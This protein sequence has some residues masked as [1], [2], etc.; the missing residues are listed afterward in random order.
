MGAGNAPLV[1]REPDSCKA[2]A[3][4][5]KL[6]WFTVDPGSALHVSLFPMNKRTFL[7]SALT[8]AS[9]GVLGRFFANSAHAQEAAESSAGAASKSEFY[10]LRVYSFQSERQRKLIDSYWS[11]AAIPAYNR[12][13]IKPV[14]VFTE[15]DNAQPNKVYVLVPYPSMESFAALPSRLAADAEYQKAGSE[16]LQVPKSDPAFVR[17]DSSLLVAFEGMKK[18]QVPGSQAD[19]KPWIF[20]LRTYESHSEAKG[21]NKVAMFNDG[22]IELMQQVGLSPVFF[23]QGLVGSRLPSLVYMISGESREAHKAHFKAFADSPVWKKLSSDPQYKDNVSKITSV[24]L[25]RTDYSQI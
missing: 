8:T 16:Y 12:A 17:L 1:C 21:I 18:L 19:K 4:H 20:E 9:A 24:F 10:E 5:P 11:A 7:A 14:G 25:Q 15:L 2:E 13:G 6:L 22:E 3:L 23:A